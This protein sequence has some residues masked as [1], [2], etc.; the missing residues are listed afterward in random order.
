MAKKRSCRRLFIGQEVV[1]TLLK[2]RGLILVLLLPRSGD[3]QWLPYAQNANI[4]CGQSDLESAV[5]RY[6]PSIS[7]GVEDTLE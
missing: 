4:I 1:P 3:F 7:A 6:I 5:D 2:E